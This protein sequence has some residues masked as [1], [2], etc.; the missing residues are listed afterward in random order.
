M[1]KSITLCLLATFVA[2]TAG[3]DTNQL[4]LLTLDQSMDMAER[5]HPKLAEAKALVEAAAGRAQ[6]AGAF[7]N[8]EAIVGAQQL[9]FNRNTSNQREYVAGVAQPIPLGGRLGRARE[10]EQLDREVRVR[11][12]E[13]VRRDLRKRVHSAFATALYQERAFQTQNHIAKSVEQVVA[14]TKA[15][16]DAGD[17]VPEDLARI[18]MELARAKVEIQRSQSMHEQAML[19]LAAAIGDASLNVKSLSGSLDSTFEIPTLEALAAS[20]STQ[21][22]I[23]LADADLRARSARIDLAKAERIPDVKIEA[24]YHRLEATKENT[25]DIGLSLPLPLFNRNQG[26]LREARAEAEAAGARSR[27]T[28]NEMNIRLRESYAQLTTALAAS[29]ALQTEILPRADTV[30]KSAEARYA[31]GDTS[32]SDVLPVRRDWAAVQ[33]SHLE[34]LRDVMLAWVQLRSIAGH[35]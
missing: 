20:L 7:P 8:P 30:L 29:R 34:S 26:R 14:T 25:F 16:I 21:P 17:A 27:L 2:L 22:E 9:P 6:Q 13:L 11:G 28:G 4:E 31:A 15:R 32:L 1:K 12:L 35:K 10:A 3:A 19:T 18:E 5:L 33:L 24:L 23:Q